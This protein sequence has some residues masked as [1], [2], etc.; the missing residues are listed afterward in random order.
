MAAVSSTD[1]VVCVR[2]A[3]LPCLETLTAR[4]IFDCLNQAHRPFGD[5]PERADHLG[6]AG[7][8]DE[9]DVAPFLDQPLGLPMNLGNQRACRIDIS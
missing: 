5:L 9:E 1:R 4:D 2:N 8:T 6:M 7:M 3:R